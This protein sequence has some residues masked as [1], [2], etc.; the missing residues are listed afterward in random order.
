MDEEYVGDGLSVPDDE[1]TIMTTWH[2]DE[3]LDDSTWFALNSA[4]PDDRFFDDCKSV[5]AISIGNDMWAKELATSLANPRS[6]T[7]RVLGDDD[8][9]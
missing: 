1:S 2:N 6:L 3:S 9:A 4:F 5:V 8:A 7:I